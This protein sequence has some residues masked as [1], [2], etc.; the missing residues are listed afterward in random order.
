MLKYSIYLMQNLSEKIR[1]F[2]KDLDTRPFPTPMNN[3]HLQILMDISVSFR[4]NIPWKL[5]EPPPLFRL[6]RPVLDRL[7]SSASPRTT[8]YWMQIPVPKRVVDPTGTFKTIFI[9]IIKTCWKHCS[10]TLSLS[11]SLAIHPYCQLLLAGPLDFIQ[12]SHRAWYMKTLIGR[13]FLA[14]PRI[15]G[16]KSLSLFHLE[17]PS[18]FVCLTWM[19]CEMGGKCRY[20]NIS[21][22][23]FT[24]RSIWGL[25]V[26]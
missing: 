17:C 18:C 26:T 21:Y 6:I 19:I 11:L 3:T 5:Y 22:W 23:L 25:S 9:Y 13:P 10:V 8:L 12:C 20:S 4:T 7:D 2:D 15:G 1:H 24:P 14:C 16:H